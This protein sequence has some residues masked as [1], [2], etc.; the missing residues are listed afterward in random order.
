MA[1]IFSAYGLE[2][3]ARD[4]ARRSFAAATISMAL[5]ICCMLLVARIRRRR[6]LRDAIFLC[7]ELRLE[8]LA[9]LVQ[10]LLVLGRDEL[11]RA[12]V[13]RHLGVPAGHEREPVG[14]ELAPRGD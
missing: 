14:F 4:C 5:K 11:R 9:G 8:R 1:V 7:L 12:D 10:P 6:S 3:C 13:V 2:A